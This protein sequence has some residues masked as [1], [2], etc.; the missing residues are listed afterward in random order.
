MK[1]FI[2]LYIGIMVIL[3]SS[4]LISGYLMV[5]RSLKKS[6]NHEVDNCVQQYNLFL[7][8]FQTN[9]IVATKNKIADPELVTEVTRLTKGNSKAYIGVFMNGIEVVYDLPEEII[10]APPE[11]DIVK[12]DIINVRDSV[13]V[14]CY[15]SFEKRGVDY[16]C[17]VAYDISKIINENNSQRRGYYMIYVIVL[18]GGTLFAFFFAMHLTKPIRHLS[19]AG[20]AIADGDYGQKIEVISNDELGE[21]T[22]TF[23]NMSETIREKMDDL[24]LSVKQKEDFIAAFAH[25]TK[26][27]MTSIIGYA[28]LIYQNKISGEEVKEAAGVIMNEGMRLQA[29]SAKL[30]DIVL[31]K[32]S[33][34]VREEINTLE[35]LDD[36][37]ATI[38]PKIEA[39]NAKV[40]YELT[41]Y[42]N[43]LRVNS[44]CRKYDVNSIL[45]S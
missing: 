1:I 40:S 33:G 29:L 18:I 7:N 24:E 8:A 38:T 37:K 4:L 20:K 12:Y 14:V 42:Y 25:E 15:S 31:L 32:E 13:Y 23:N 21:L 2:K 26:S 22:T 10:Y 11:K 3:V 41:D 17:V 19:E 43:L 34:I 39:K 45:V 6:L 28:D 5:D 16:T 36:I 30:M 27:P 35:M 9:L 44:F